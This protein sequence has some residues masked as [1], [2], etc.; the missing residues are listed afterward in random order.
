M[1]RTDIQACPK[2]SACAAVFPIALTDVL[3]NGALL[4]L[5]YFLMW[6]FVFL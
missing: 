2:H 6:L 5:S 4:P 1:A 3:V